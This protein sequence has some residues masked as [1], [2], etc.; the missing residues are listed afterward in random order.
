MGDDSSGVFLSEMKAIVISMLSA[1]N[2]GAKVRLPH[3]TVMTFLFRP[4]LPLKQK[5][6]VIAKATWTHS[7]NLGSFAF[8][9]KTVLALLKIQRGRNFVRKYTP[10]LPAH[11]CDSIIAGGVGGYVIWGR[12]NAINYQ[13]ALYIFSRVIVGLM[14][15]AQENSIPLF[16]SSIARTRKVYP[17][18]ASAVWAAVMFL[19]EEFPHV[20]HASL[21][22]SM[23]EI[24]RASSG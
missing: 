22:R 3:A 23:D 24:Y 20:L 8:I 18:F 10:G 16:S 9:Y 13:I 21:K 7:V 17:I 2:Y 14:G 11:S 5:I 1:A 15:L 12:Y 4:N 19:F 6:K